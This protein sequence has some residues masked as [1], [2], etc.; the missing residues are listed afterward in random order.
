MSRRAAV[1]VITCAA[2]IAGGAVTTSAYLKLGFFT[3][4]G[5][6]GI[7]WTRPI[8]YFITNRDADGVTAPQMQAAMG[9]AFATWAAVPNVVV[10]S[11]FSGFTGAEPFAADGINAIGFR[12]RP[13]LERTLGATTFEVDDIT[14]QIL[15]SD[16]F[17]N[18]AFTWSVASGGQSGRFD[19]ESV[20]VH[21]VGHLL[22]MGHSALGETE[23]RA[24]GG[25]RVLGKRAVM[26]PIAYPAGIIEDR[27]LEADDRAGIVD[28]YGSSAA[29]ARTGSISGRVTLGAA[30]VFGAHITAMH[31]STGDLV[32]TFS[33]TANGDFAIAGLA[34]GLYVVRVEPLDDADIDSFFDD[35]GTVNANFRA[36]FFSKLVSVPRGGSGPS[37]EIKVVAK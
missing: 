27:T 7:H 8:T 30:G 24:E 2:L 19:L 31:T 6:V 23:V 15:E 37:V 25:R 17:F 5:L 9:R 1:H 11:T 35:D 12:A 33:L 16:I 28:I 3:P 14:G 32:S 20:G 34:P 29:A 21:E 10:T 18:T 13:E 26:F 4:S 36:A 22:G